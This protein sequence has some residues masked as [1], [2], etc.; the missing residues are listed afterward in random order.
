MSDVISGRVWVFGDDINTD[1][2]MPGAVLYGSEQEQT[3]ALFASLR[4]GWVDEVRRGDIVVAGCNFGVGSSR[5]AARSLVNVGVACLIAESINTL[6]FRAC[7]S[8]GLVAMN[9]PG[10]TQFAREGDEIEVDAAKGLVRNPA[11]AAA[12]QGMPTPAD[13]LSIMRAGGMLPMME[14]EGL[15]SPLRLSA[16]RSN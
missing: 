3:R 13:L 1:V 16:Y 7:V 4:P 8:Y 5:P 11:T 9:C 10:V 12:L 14:A 15:I 2:M 6:F